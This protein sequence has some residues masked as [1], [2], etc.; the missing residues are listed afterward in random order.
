VCAR[1]GEEDGAHEVHRVHKLNLR[2]YFSFS[3]MLII[4]VFMSIYWC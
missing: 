2:V 3:G 1:E 4:A